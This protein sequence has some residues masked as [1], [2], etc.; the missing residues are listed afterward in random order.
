MQLLPSALPNSLTRRCRGR[1]AAGHDTSVDTPVDTGYRQAAT[2]GKALCDRNH[3]PT[4]RR[5]LSARPRASI[6]PLSLRDYGA[7]SHG[8]LI[9]RPRPPPFGGG[10]F[11]LA[12]GCSAG[13]AGSAASRRHLQP[14]TLR[15]EGSRSWANVCRRTVGEHFR[16]AGAPAGHDIACLLASGRRRL[17]GRSSGRR[18]LSVD[19]TIERPSAGVYFD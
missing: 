12:S 5:A 4:V 6:S 18:V 7:R 2:A 11:G 14:L 19:S 10:G 1:V 16:P 13:R 15:P 8:R 3:S 17:F 9:G